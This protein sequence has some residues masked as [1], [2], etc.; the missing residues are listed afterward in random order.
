MVKYDIVQASCPKSSSYQVSMR[1][2]YGDFGDAL[3]KL[4]CDPI[5]VQRTFHTILSW[6]LVVLC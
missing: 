4:R 2:D 5:A 6:Q 1:I 3:A